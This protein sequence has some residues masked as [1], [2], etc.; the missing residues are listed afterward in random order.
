MAQGTDIVPV[1]G[2][3]TRERLTESLG[4]ADLTLTADDL[5]TIE[6]AVPEGSAKGD[7]YPSAMMGTLGTR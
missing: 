6:R 4:A 5:A 1:V 2:A 7:R 3:R